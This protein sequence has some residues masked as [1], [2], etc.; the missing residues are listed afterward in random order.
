MKYPNITENP[1]SV[2]FHSFMVIYICLM[3][4]LNPIHLVLLEHNAK[5][6]KTCLDNCS[7]IAYISLLT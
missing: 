2:S 6:V 5:R 1:N 4:F 3:S 7:M